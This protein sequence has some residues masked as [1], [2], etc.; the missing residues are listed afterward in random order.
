MELTALLDSMGIEAVSGHPAGLEISA[1][2]DDSRQCGAGVLFVA[3]AG[4][5]ADGHDF[6]AQAA[7]AGAA[8]ALVERVPSGAPSGLAL[9]QVPNTRRALALASQKMAGDPSRRMKLFGVTGT[10]GKTTVAYLMESI[11]Q[12]AGLKPGMLGTIE[13]RWNGGVEVASHTTPSPTHLAATMKRMADDGVEAAVMEVSSHALDQHRVDGLHF[14]AGGFTNLTQDHLD[15][16][17]TMQE[18]GEAK[19]RFFTEV[20]AESSGA[21]VL[22]LDDPWGWI[23]ARDSRAARTLGFSYHDPESDIQLSSVAFCNRGFRMRVDIGGEERAFDSPMHGMFNVQNCL[24]ALSLAW[25]GG[26]G[27]DAIAKGLAAMK[28]APGRFEFID[29]GQPFSVIVDYAHTPDALLQV[30]LNARGHARRRLIAVLGCGGDRDKG[31]RALMGRAAARLAQIAIVTNDNP[32]TEDPET[33]ADAIEA[34]IADVSDSAVIVERQLDRRKAIR[35]AI[36]LAKPGDAIV[37]AGKGHE[38][39]QILGTKK[40]H[41]DDREEV[42]VALG[43]G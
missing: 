36:R 32:R 19:K 29:C 8:A 24:T 14:C 6:L 7:Q 37:I 21:A 20:L 5:Q 11:F 26:I 17:K 30:L 23:Y 27:L 35:R 39:Y 40:T 28:G 3:I 41:F 31:K 12:A 42:R 33:I 22:N 38:D 9:I 10:N 13:Y 16:H 4:T 2:T 1:L 43:E 34:G 25:A 15:Y 18:Y